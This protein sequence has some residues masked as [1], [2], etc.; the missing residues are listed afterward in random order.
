MYSLYSLLLENLSVLTIT[1]L[2][3][4]NHALFNPY[5]LVLSFMILN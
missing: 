4:F 1:S 5:D 3:M 2:K